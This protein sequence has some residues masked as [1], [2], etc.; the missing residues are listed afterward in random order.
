MK[1]MN[2]KKLEIQNLCKHCVYQIEESILESYAWRSDSPVWDAIKDNT[3][4][5]CEDVSTHWM[6]VLLVYTLFN[7]FTVCTC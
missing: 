1:P 3:V 2:I 7:V 4:P 5:N 6:F